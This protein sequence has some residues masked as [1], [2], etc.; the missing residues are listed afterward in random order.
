MIPP[1]HD[2]RGP[3]RRPGTGPLLVLAAVLTSACATNPANRRAALIADADREAK[4]ALAAESRLNTA[5]IPP[6]TVAVVPFTVSGGDTLLTP[7]GFGLADLLTTDLSQSSDLQMVERLR[8]DAILRELKLVDAGV[9]DTRTAPRAGRLMGARRLITGGIIPGRAGTIHLQA[10][11]IDVVN[12]TV[13]DVASAD[14]PVVRIFDAEKSLALLLLGRLGINV[15]PAQR[16][17]IEQRQNTQ[18]AT[19]VAFG[20]G[21]EAEAHGDAAAAVAAFEEASRLD[22]AFVASHAR[23]AAAPSAAS[24]RERSVQRVVSLSA[25]AL[26]APAAAHVSEVADAPLP[27]SLTIPILITIRVLP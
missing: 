23:V 19:L 5:A 4:Q 27:A 1:I 10:R 12:G 9:T 20:R 2:R 26:N 18:L 17:A 14:V 16:V 8:I 15:T 13:Q 6:R 3:A 7:L 21:A 11:V 25:S 24:S 22:A